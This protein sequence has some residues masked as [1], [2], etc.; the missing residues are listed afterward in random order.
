MK[1][2]KFIPIL[3]VRS[4]RQSAHF[5]KDNFGFIA[6]WEHQFGPDFPLFISMSL[7]SLQLF[8]SEHKGSGMENAE[9]YVYIDNVDS[10]YAQLTSKGVPVEQPPTDQPWRVRDMKLQD[11]DQHRFIFAARLS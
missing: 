1:E 6:N 9:L 10:L 2:S 4:A 5:Y 3:R 8:L 11:L 7:G